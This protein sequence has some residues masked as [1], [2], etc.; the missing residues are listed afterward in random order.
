[1]WYIIKRSGELLAGVPPPQVT[2][3]RSLVAVGIVEVQI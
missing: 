3:L 1:M 2:I